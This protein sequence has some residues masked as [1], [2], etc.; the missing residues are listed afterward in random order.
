MSEPDDPDRRKVLKLATCA[1]G[2][3]LGL[4]IVG[5]V[6][7]LVT[8]PAGMQTVSVPT[9]PLDLGPAAVLKVGGKW[10][11][12]QVVAPV[13]SDAWT[14][15][16]DVVLG[17]AFVRRISDTKF[18]ARSSV[19]P[20]LGCAVGYDPGSDTF[21]CPC[22]NSK[23]DSNGAALPGGKAKRALDPLEIDVKDGRLRLKWQMFKLDIA[24]SE[25]V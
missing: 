1:L 24:K 12:L 15:A 21:L 5:P 13:V 10:K 14:S 17:A 11:Q 4:A 9:E 18:E 22:H 2:G 7:K 3:G 23:F 8:A 16:R 25:P 19:C 20:H 6:V